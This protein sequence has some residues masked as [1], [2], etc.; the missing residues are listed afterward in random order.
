MTDL[1]FVLYFLRMVG[2]FHRSPSL[3]IFAF[4]KRQ[5]EGHG[6][7]NAHILGKPGCKEIYISDT[8]RVQEEQALGYL[9]AELDESVFAIVASL[10]R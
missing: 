1:V 6:F 2:F 7:C 5:T 4:R 10:L 8:L 3:Y 9:F